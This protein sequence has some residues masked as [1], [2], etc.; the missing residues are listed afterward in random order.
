MSTRRHM[1]LLVLFAVVL[2]AVYAT[3]MAYVIGGTL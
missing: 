1:S 3:G 2:V